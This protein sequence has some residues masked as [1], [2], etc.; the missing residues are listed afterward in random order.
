MAVGYS[1]PLNGPQQA[2]R[3]DRHGRI[4]ALP[5]L[6]NHTTGWALNINQAGTII[7]VEHFTNDRSRAVLW[8][9]RHWPWVRITQRLLTTLVRPLLA[10]QPATNGQRQLRA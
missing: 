8:P 6:P 1:Q 3:W 4:T 7:G 5:T 10:A 2:V 9:V